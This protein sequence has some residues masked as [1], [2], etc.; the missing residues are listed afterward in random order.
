MRPLPGEICALRRAQKSAEAVVVKRALERGQ[1]RRAEGTKA[2]LYRAL[3]WGQI[4]PDVS[5]PAARLLLREPRRPVRWNRDKPTG[6]RP[7]T[8]THEL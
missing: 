2:K 4:N 7:A 6:E 3:C 1:E 8:H 5:S